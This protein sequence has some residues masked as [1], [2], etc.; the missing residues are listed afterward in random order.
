MLLFKDVKPNYPIYILDRKNVEYKEGKVKEVNLP[1]L[2]N[3]NPMVIGKMVVDVVIESEGNTGSY[4]IQDNV[5]IASAFNGDIILSTEKEGLL[6]ELE[7][8]K[9]SKEQYLEGVQKAEEDLEKSKK[10]LAE[11]NPL[12]KEKQENEKRFTNIENSISEMSQ[13]LK[14]QQDMMAKFIEG[15]KNK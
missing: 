4:T 14:T 5:C 9:S 6:P 10:L 15:F 8:I 1:H 11:L 7:S 13:M 2:D 3:S 12:L